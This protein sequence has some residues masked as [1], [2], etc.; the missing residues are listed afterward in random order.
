MNRGSEVESKLYGSSFQIWPIISC[1][2]NFFAS[3]IIELHHPA[4]LINIERIPLPITKMNPW[5]RFLSPARRHLTSRFA[6]KVPR[7][8]CRHVSTTKG[9]APTEPNKAKYISQLQRMNNR[10]KCL[11]SAHDLR[12]FVPA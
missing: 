9:S 4:P 2:T 5:H 7:N 10:R 11:L 8:G 3:R 1:E 12:V 6:V